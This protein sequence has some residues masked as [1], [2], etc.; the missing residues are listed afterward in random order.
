MNTELTPKRLE[1][2]SELV[3]RA[4]VVALLVNP[5][6]LSAERIIRDVE[7]AARVKRVQLRTLKASAE[8]DFETAFATIV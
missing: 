7:E 4:D 3:P 8:G 2:L 1:L 5:N 6:S